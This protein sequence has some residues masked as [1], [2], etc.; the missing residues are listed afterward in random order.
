MRLFLLRICG[1]DFGRILFIFILVLFWFLLIFIGI[2]RFIVG[3]IWS[4]IVVLVFM[5]CFFI[6]LLWWILCIEYC[7]WSVGIRL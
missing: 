1:G 4:V 3:S 2:C 6:C 7:V 5:K